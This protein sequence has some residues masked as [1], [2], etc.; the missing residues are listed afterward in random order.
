MAWDYKR[1][2]KLAIFISQPNMDEYKQKDI[3]MMVDVCGWE[4]AFHFYEQYEKAYGIN[5][6]QQREWIVEIKDK[7]E[8]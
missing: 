6:I 3:E 1:M 5:C 2:T 8:E 4:T 7:E